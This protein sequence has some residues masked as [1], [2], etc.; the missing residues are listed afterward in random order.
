MTFVVITG[1]DR[2]EFETMREALSYRT[3]VSRIYERD[4]FGNVVPL[5]NAKIQEYLQHE[6]VAKPPKKEEKAADQDL[7]NTDAEKSPQTTIQEDKLDKE[8]SHLDQLERERTSDTHEGAKSKKTN[9]LTILIYV[10]M[11]AII[12]FFLLMII[13]PFFENF[14][15]SYMNFNV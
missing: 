1:T 9:L 10:F 4:T 6:P 14:F 8:L 3:A 7:L 2:K 13:R 12:I 15:N 5:D 11:A